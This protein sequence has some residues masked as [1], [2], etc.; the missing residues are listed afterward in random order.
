VFRFYYVGN[1]S[2]LTKIKVVKWGIPWAT[3]FPAAALCKEVR[4][5][6]GASA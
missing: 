2:P 3:S 5:A 6:G 4:L 1:P